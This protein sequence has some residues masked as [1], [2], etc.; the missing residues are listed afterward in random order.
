MDQEIVLSNQHIKE[1][2]MALLSYYISSV[3]NPRSEYVTRKAIMLSIKA[4]DAYDGILDD[5]IEQ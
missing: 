1:N 4:I 5:D 3:N 2:L